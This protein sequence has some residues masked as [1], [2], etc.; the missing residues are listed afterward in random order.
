[1]GGE[2]SADW[3]AH[4]E[5]EAILIGTQDMLLARAL[6]RGYGLFPA[7]W[8]IDVGVINTEPFGFSTKYS[9]WGLSPVRERRHGRERHYRIAPKRLVVIRDWIA[10]YERF[11]G[12]VHC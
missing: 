9:S 1:M 8:P 3:Q 12:R 10:R 7:Y 4:P 6:N 5:R 2:E 11:D